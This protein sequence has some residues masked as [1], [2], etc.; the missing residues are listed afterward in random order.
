MDPRSLD[1]V[2]TDMPAGKKRQFDNTVVEQINSQISER[3]EK[4]RPSVMAFVTIGLFILSNAEFVKQADL[5]PTIVNILLILAAI[6]TVGS[7]L[8]RFALNTRGREDIRFISK[9]ENQF[10]PKFG[11][12]ANDWMISSI[13]EVKKVRSDFKV[14]ELLFAQILNVDGFTIFDLAEGISEGDE[15]KFYNFIIKEYHTRAIHNKPPFYEQV[16]HIVD[17]Y[18]S[19]LLIVVGLRKLGFVIPD[20][21][22]D[23]NIMDF[24]KALEQTEDSKFLISSIAD[25][26]WRFRE[27]TQLWSEVELNSVYDVIF[28]VLNLYLIDEIYSKKITEEQ[29]VLFKKF[30]DFYTAGGLEIAKTRLVHSEN[31][32]RPVDDGFSDAD[33]LSL[34]S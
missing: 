21:N 3:S 1:E 18:Y 19:K 32:E 22:V 25:K 23:S 15:D 29:R 17:R 14:E 28:H 31:F 27:F 9:F 6:T 33:T 4:I 10:I 34:E 13:E 30:V 11:K 16:P 8:H 24:L 2:N 20:E 12:V 26:I 7:F 5:F